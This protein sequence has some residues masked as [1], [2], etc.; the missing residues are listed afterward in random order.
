MFFDYNFLNYKFF[1]LLLFF[2]SCMILQIEA[3]IVLLCTSYFV[4]FASDKIYEY[5]VKIRSI[6]NPAFKKTQNKTENQQPQ[7]EE[8]R[9]V[10]L[11]HTNTSQVL[12]EEVR[13]E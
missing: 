2:L 6:V 11:S 9:K 12:K 5:Y 4:F 7:S 3:I 10:T 13:K 1:S 8:K